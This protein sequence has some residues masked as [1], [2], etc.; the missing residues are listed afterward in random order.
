MADFLKSPQADQERG[1]GKEPKATAANTAAQKSATPAASASNLTK[2]IVFGVLLSG[3]ALGLLWAGPLAFALLILA[4]SLIMAWEWGRVVRGNDQ[5]VTMLVHGVAV[6]VAIGLAAFGYAAL[7]AAVIVI[8][9]IIVALLEFGENGAL[10]TLG[11]LYTGVPAV[12][13]L[14]LR[15]QEPNGLYAILFLF[16]VVWTT[17]TLAYAAGRLIGG[18]KLAP[19]ISPKKTWAGFVFGVGGAVL[20]GWLFARWIGAPEHAM[21][22][23]AGVLAVISQIGDLAE[24][25]LKRRF[26]I[27]DS[28]HLIPGHGGFLDRVD[29]LVPAIIAATIFAFV[30]NAEMPVE[31]LLFLR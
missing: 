18:P 29:S 10:S 27:K 14:W 11:V 23:L 19:T 8:A 24:S 13:L 17:D 25:A 12:A 20:V 9:A 5:D 16:A 21:A 28:S 30:M 1:L 4:V 7:G 15:S 6:T 2:R 3:V 26:D 22:A 31:A